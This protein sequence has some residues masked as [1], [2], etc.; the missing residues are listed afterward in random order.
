M[1]MIKI[2]L[3]VF[4]LAG[5]MLLIVS[6]LADSGRAGTLIAGSILV[7]SGLISLAIIESRN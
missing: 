6:S 5:G 1:T 2:V 7:G 4:S 3:T